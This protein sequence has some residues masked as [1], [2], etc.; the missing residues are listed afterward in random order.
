MSEEKKEKRTSGKPQVVV[1]KKK[2]KNIA[3]KSPRFD[4]YSPSSFANM[5]HLWHHRENLR[6]NLLRAQEKASLS[7]KGSRPH[8][9]VERIQ[10]YL[11]HLEEN[12]SH[13]YEHIRIL[14]DMILIESRLSENSK[15]KQH[16]QKVIDILVAPFDN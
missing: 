16:L 13:F 11:K 1:A 7:E 5:S 14:M 3:V 2:K 12:K 6:K 4:M 10:R 9:D 15:Y 8:L